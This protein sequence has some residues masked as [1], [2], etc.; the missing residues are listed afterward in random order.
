VT[1][2]TTAQKP[3]GRPFPGPEA[4]LCA[5]P[6]DTL[7]IDGGGPPGIPRTGTVIAV[8]DPGGRPPYLVRWTTGDYVSRVSPGP[9]A[10]IERHSA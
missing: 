6:G 8:A 10:R 3:G 5:E 9:G 7:L 1:V 4:A 2:S